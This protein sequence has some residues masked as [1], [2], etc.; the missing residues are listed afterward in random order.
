ML[1]ITYTERTEMKENTM[2][3][4]LKGIP[5]RKLQLEMSREQFENFIH[6]DNVVTY[7]RESGLMQNNEETHGN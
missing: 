5:C 7:L 4:S 1:H 3:I 2:G 6:R